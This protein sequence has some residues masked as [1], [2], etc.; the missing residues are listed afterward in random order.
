MSSSSSLIGRRLGKY[1]I[2]E[3]LGQGGMATVYKGYQAEMDR[4]VAIKVLPPHPGQDR[5]FMDRFRLEAR[6]VAQLQHPHILPV[7]DYGNEDGILYLVMAYVE[8]GSLKDR[9]DRGPLS[10][11]ETETILRQVASALDYAHRRNVVH[12]DIKPDN[13]LLDGEGN[14]ILSDFG[15]VKILEGDNTGGLTGT[16]GVLGTPAYMAPE[17]SQGA[18]ITPKADIYALGVIVFEMLTGQQPYQADTPMQV[19]LKHISEPVPSLTEQVATLPPALEVVMINVLAKHPEDRYASATEFA[20]EFLRAQH[21]DGIS[22]TSIPK[23]SPTQ[24]E[25]VSIT[26]QPTE[27][28]RPQH[29]TAPQATVS[30]VYETGQTVPPPV[31]HGTN[32]LLLLGG[33]AIIALLAVIIVLLV[34]S[35]NQ[36]QSVAVIPTALATD[37]PPAATTVPS[38]VPA[39]SVAASG[40]TAV[41]VKIFG[42]LSYSTT[43]E[44]GDTINLEFDGV[45]QPPSGKRYTV[46]LKNTADDSV[47]N[48]GTMSPDGMGRGV[49]R[50]VDAENRLLPALYNAVLITVEDDAGDEP[51]GEVIYSGS[52]P[53]EVREALSEIFVSSENGVSGGSLYG[54][55]LA[56]AELSVIHTSLDHTD[57]YDHFGLL[58][59]TEHTINI[60]MNTEIDYDGNGIAENPGFQLGLNHF[61]DQID[62]RLDFDMT[63]ENIPSELASDVLRVEHCLRNARQRL[64]QLVDLETGWGDL[65]PESVTEDFARAEISKSEATITNL[66]DGVDMN[67]NNQIEGFPGECGLRQIPAFGLLI[68]SM[69]IVEG[70]LS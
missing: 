60:L 32:P 28:A 39:T 14:A 49:H 54:G 41:P 8:G 1:E 65:D 56:E 23:S 2:T 66:I 3:L 15:I 64:N 52:T 46:W 62:S 19:I 67:R 31:R 70:D 29:V 53:D 22:I 20:Q 30:P 7:H 26:P 40:P 25:R 21:N 61:L 58:N 10:I 50:Y 43:N 44:L 5:Q 63:V 47:L 38:D 34:V 51:A 69:D 17:Q 35:N 24:T 42:G 11:Q 9:I 18:E 16:G 36:P 33:F 48:I 59:R 13:I 4:F 37:V 27:T 57:R 45:R 12:R 55:A 6:T 68:G